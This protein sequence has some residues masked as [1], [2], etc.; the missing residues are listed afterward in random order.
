MHSTP[1]NS[2]SSSVLKQ[3]NI[4]PPD[5][6]MIYFQK[7]HCSIL[8]LLFATLLLVD[9][10]SDA[11]VEP[12]P[13]HLP[14]ICFHINNA[15]ISIQKLFPCCSVAHIGLPLTR[16]APVVQLRRLPSI[17]FHVAIQRTRRGPVRH[18]TPQDFGIR[19]RVMECTHQRRENKDACL[20][21]R[22]RRQP[23]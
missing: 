4:F 21:Q 11:L 14:P 23:E 1:D 13:L 16:A 9:T 20:Y 7:T 6:T 8:C 3:G 15:A 18:D 19:H 17:C 10:R 2:S 22:K 5:L 12:V